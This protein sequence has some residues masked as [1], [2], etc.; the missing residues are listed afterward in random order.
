MSEC[1]NAEETISASLVEVIPIIFNVGDL[2]EL[3]S[4][5]TWLHGNPPLD[6]TISE[7]PETVIGWEL[8]WAGTGDPPLYALGSPSSGEETSLG[9]SGTCK[10]VHNVVLEQ[11]MEHRFLNFQKVHID[12]LLHHEELQNP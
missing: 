10:F 1:D 8:E 11:Y 6:D 4:V 9:H 7:I 5:P 3:E 2:A 12:I